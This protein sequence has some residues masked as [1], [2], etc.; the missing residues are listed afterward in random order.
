MSEDILEARAKV[1]KVRSQAKTRL[2]RRR[3]RRAEEGL[4]KLRD[5]LERGAKE[6]LVDNDKVYVAVMVH[7]MPW[8]KRV[9]LGPGL[10]A[11]VGNCV[12]CIC[13]ISTLMVFLVLV[14]I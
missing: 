1:K 4:A 5:E 3:L 14:R 7:T 9:F 2:R 11:F 12:S 13:S 8:R 10:R 6:V